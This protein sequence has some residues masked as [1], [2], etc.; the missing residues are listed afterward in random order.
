MTSTRA[1]TFLLPILLVACADAP[2]QPA[3]S[4]AADVP[5]AAP[6]AQGALPD[7]GACIAFV[8]N[9]LAFDG[10]TRAALREQAGEPV[11]VQAT[12]AQG[13]GNA[14]DSLFLVRYTGMLAS[15]HKPAGAAELLDGVRV[16]DNRWLR[17]PEAGIGVTAEMVERLLGP[18]AERTD[19]GLTYACHSHP[20]QDD[21]V[22]F[23][24]AGGRVVEV[25]YT[26][27]MD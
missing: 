27:F 20:A 21:P 25:V 12:T 9:G 6:L 23:R 24:L 18:P 14:Q 10:R 4:P 26:F 11:S 5:A 22:T 7:S 1:R 8:E 15:L 17:Y 13:F 3:P 19:E 16:S 2:E